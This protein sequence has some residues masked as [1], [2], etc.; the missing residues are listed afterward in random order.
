MKTALL[1]ILALILSA[2]LRSQNVPN[3]YESIGKQAPNV[4]TLSNGEYDEFQLKSDLVLINGDA[5]DRKT[6]ELVCSKEDN[7]ELIASIDKSDADRFRFLSTDP[8][9][10]SFPELSPYQYASNNPIQNVDLDGLEGIP[11]QP[12][13]NGGFTTPL[14]AT[15][16][17]S[18]PQIKLVNF[19]VIDAN[20]ANLGFAEPPY[21]P[22]TQVKEFKAPS[23][24]QYVRVFT[25]GKTAPQGQWMMK[26]QDIEGM[27][28]EEIQSTFSLPNT[29]THQ[30]TVDVPGGTTI[31]TGTAGPAFNQQG[32][33]TQYQLMEKIPAESFGTPKALPAV[34][35]VEPTPVI[36]EPIIEPE[37]VIEPILPP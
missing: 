26:A 10:K 13:Q 2:A 8:L 4:V 6:G 18:A 17:P 16:H 27:T 24:Q 7:P 29:P 31:R 15:Y 30:V 28:P 3:P 23:R 35:V 21:S 20:V 36:E 33:G 25:E 22:T 11:A 12:L 34:P 1:F 37:P 9:S 32:G 14:D 19:K 5:V